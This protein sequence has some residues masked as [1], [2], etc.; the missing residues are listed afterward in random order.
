MRV[1]IKMRGQVLTKD[2]PE[3]PNVGDG[4]RVVIPGA[5]PQTVNVA[6]R[7]W[8]LEP[9]KDPELELDCV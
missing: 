4:I 6:E 1:H 7:V 3:A 9:E 5:A 2:M 8:I